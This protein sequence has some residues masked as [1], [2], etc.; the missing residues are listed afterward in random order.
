[1][2]TETR[3]QSWR[4]IE[5][6]RAG[7]P[8]PDAVHALGSSQSE[9]ESSF[10]DLLGRL[11][12]D[13]S[14]EPAG[15]L[16]EGDF[17][18]GKSHLLEF[19]H[20]IALENNF[21]CSKFAVSKNTP[22]YDPSKM[23]RAAVEVANVPK[24][25]GSAVANIVNHI[26]FDSAEYADFFRWVN[27]ME[28]GLSNLFA[29]T[30][31]VHEN[32]RDP[33]ILNRIEQFWAGDKLNKPEVRAWLRDLAALAAYRVDAVR[34][35]ELVAQ[36][37]MFFSRL[38]RASGFAG[39]V[40]LIDELELVGRYS[41]RQRARSYA[42]LARLLG[43]LEGS[44]LPG[45]GAVFAVSADFCTAVLDDPSLK[46]DVERIPNRLRSGGS[47]DDLL[48]ASQAERGMRL[49]QRY[50]R[51]IRP[52]TRDDM[53]NINTRVRNLY[54][55]AYDWVVPPTADSLDLSARLRTNLKRW[56]NE[57]DLSRLYPNHAGDTEVEEVALGSYDEQPELEQSDAEADGGNDQ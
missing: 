57:W 51:S 34:A 53:C 16:I 44:K 12:E 32:S 55:D 27:S 50:R 9:I 49:I 25:T 28:C 56:I 39:W 19:L 4:A 41:F 7:V 6:M 48:L 20:S 3:V 11:A 46:H 21:V 47:D 2:S 14:Q 42:E 40:V 30:V 1:M 10:R 22:L 8:N 23:Y 38:I 35:K 45:V 26:D 13:D 15:F 18:S 43:R 54:Q 33:E 31:F 17:G 24:R 29:A 37:F 52:P 36:R 5:A